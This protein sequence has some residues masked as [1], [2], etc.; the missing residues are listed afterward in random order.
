MCNVLQFTKKVL[1]R[2][3]DVTP[4]VIASNCGPTYKAKKINVVSTRGSTVDSYV[5]RTQFVHSCKHG[6]L[7]EPSALTIYK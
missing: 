1:T 3:S 4:A 7:L 6:C 5:G 2:C